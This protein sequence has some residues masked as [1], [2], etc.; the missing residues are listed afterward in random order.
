[1]TEMLGKQTLERAYQRLH[2]LQ[3]ASRCW[4]ARLLSPV[5]ESLSELSAEI[6]SACDQGTLWMSHAAV[7]TDALLNEY[8]QSVQK[9]DRVAACSAS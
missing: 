5:R 1:M 6:N 3:W 9:Y 8:W 7:E 4:V 2:R